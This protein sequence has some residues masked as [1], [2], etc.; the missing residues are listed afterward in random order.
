[1]DNGARACVCVCLTNITARFFTQFH[2]QLP[3]FHNKTALVQDCVTCPLLYW[4]VVAVGS[5]TS[6]ALQSVR[7]RLVWPVRRLAAESALQ[8]RPLAIIQAL[9]IL[10]L[11]PMPFAALIDDP[12][13]SFS[14]LATHKALL[15]G[16]HRPFDELVRQA[17]GDKELAKVMQFTWT[18]CCIVAQMYVLMSSSPHKRGIFR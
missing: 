10:C 11:W 13:W 3:F 9:L 7:R 4:A 5:R 15:L 18:T 6:P 12:S 1:V 17:N 8:P 16:L 14:G 2:P